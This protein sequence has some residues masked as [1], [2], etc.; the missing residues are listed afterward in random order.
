VLCYC[1]I[2][3]FPNHTSADIELRALSLPAIKDGDF[4]ICG[5]TACVHYLL[6]K[7]GQKASSVLS[8]LL[9]GVDNLSALLSTAQTSKSEGKVLEFCLWPLVV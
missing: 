9:L 3:T 2:V 4:V 1:F 6:L 7:A 8:S 5:A